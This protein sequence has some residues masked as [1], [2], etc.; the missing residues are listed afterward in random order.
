MKVGDL[1]K[2]RV[3]DETSRTVGTSTVRGGHAIINAGKMGLVT[4]AMEGEDGFY[5]YEVTFVD[6]RGWYSDLELE[7][8]QNSGGKRVQNRGE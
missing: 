3:P 4:D 7:I 1:V 6:D 5:D 8:I 2:V